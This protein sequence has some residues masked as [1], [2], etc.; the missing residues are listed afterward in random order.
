LA[1]VCRRVGDWYE[2]L[3]GE[4]SCDTATCEEFGLTL[5]GDQDGRRREIA[6]CSLRDWRSYF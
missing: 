2:T 1:L 4:G 6:P 3:E 5:S